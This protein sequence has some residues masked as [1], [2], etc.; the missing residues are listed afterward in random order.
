MSLIELNDPAPK[1]DN[2]KLSEF[3]YKWYT[4]FL[5]QKNMIIFKSMSI[6]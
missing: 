5:A 2:A 3:K 1:G 6:F 4:N